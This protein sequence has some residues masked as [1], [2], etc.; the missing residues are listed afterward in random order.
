MFHDFILCVSTLLATLGNKPNGVKLSTSKDSL[1]YLFI[2]SLLVSLTLLWKCYRES[3]S[4]SQ[5]LSI[6]I[7]ITFLCHDA[8][9]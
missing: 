8:L 6:C 4:D 9:I 2:K 1:K 3:L 7:K 5:V